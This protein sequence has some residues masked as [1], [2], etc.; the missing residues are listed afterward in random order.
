MEWTEHQIA[1]LRQDWAEGLSTRIIGERLGFS[2]N[3]IVGKAHRLDLPPRPSPVRRRMLDGKFVPNEAVPRRHYP[4]PALPALACIMVPLP[5]ISV[6][7]VA[8]VVK[9][10]APA[11]AV[12]APPSAESPLPWQGRIAPCCWPE[13]EPGT[14]SFRF[15]REPSKPGQVYCSDHMKRAY[16][17]KGHGHAG[18]REDAA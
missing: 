3:S 16:I 4:V 14:K 13:G 6:I 17:P 15:C 2:K 7:A 9:R 12:V 5:N 1:R 18:W 8:R 11:S 10:K